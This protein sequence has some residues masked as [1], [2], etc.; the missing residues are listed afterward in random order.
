[1]KNTMKKSIL[2]RVALL[3]TLIFAV[4]IANGSEN[5][6]NMD[7]VGTFVYHIEG[8]F[9]DFFSTKDK[10]PYNAHMIKLE[11]LLNDFKRKVEESVTRGSN[12]QLTQELNDIIDYIVYQFSIAYNIMK[13][14]NG[15]P[16]SEAMAFGTEIKYGFNTEKI[17]AEIVTKLTVLKK[18][19]ES[20]NECTLATKAQKIITMI[21]KKRKEWAAKSESTLFTGLTYRMT[22]K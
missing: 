8:R 17:F 6:K 15:K 21:D 2:S 9:S 22:C 12:D 18:K 11:Q 1:M 20:A 13:K 4:G 5:E 10:N 19:A 3:A 16:A 7:N 14:Y